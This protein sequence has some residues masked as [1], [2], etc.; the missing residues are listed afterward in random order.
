MN[1]LTKVLSS[2]GI[3]SLAIATIV[4]VG[5][6]EKTQ[7]QVAAPPA[8]IIKNGEEC[9][10]CG[11]YINRFPGPKGQVFERGLASPKRFCST[12]DMFAYVL[13]PEHQHR[14][15]HI[16][17]HDVASA[18]WDE[19]GNAQYTNAKNAYFVTGHKLQGAMGP[20]LA[21]FARQ[22]DAVA[23]AEKQGGK[24]LT[25]EQVDINVLNHMS[26]QAMHHH[27]MQHNEM[28]H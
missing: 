18:P 28:Q 4:L 15:E 1:R 12:R 25:F 6:G 24:V 23:F 19:Q 21:S 9:D 5:C 26:H 11:M 17:V 10:L 3:I 27:S 16:Y 13:Q 2:I 20:A 8:V 7:Q 22:A 14:A